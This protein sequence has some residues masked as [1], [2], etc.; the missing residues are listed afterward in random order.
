MTTLNPQQYAA[1]TSTAPAILCIAGAGTGKTATLTARIKHLIAT[2]TPPKHITAL[3]FT[4]KAAAEML[5]RVGAKG[6]FIDTF[7]AWCLRMMRDIG[8]TAGWN[9][10]RLSIIDDGDQ[11]KIMDGIKK[12]M[13]LKPTKNPNLKAE[14]AALLRNEYRAFCLTHDII[15]YDMLQ[16]E[17]R[18]ILTFRSLGETPR[19]RGH[20]LIDEFQDTDPVQYEIIR[21]A[22]EHDNL[23]VVGDD[24]QSIYGFRGAD[25]G[26]I[27]QF[28]SDF[29]PEIVALTQNYRSG[30]GILDY[31]NAIEVAAIPKRLWSEIPAGTVEIQPCDAVADEALYVAKTAPALEGTTA[32]IG[33]TNSYLDEF[34]VYLE[35]EKVEFTRSRRTVWTK[36]EKASINLLKTIVTGNLAW[37]QGYDAVHVASAVP[38]APWNPTGRLKEC[39]DQY[40]AISAMLGEAWTPQGLLDFIDTYENDEAATV[41]PG[42]NLLT[43]HGSKGLEF[44]NVFLVGCGEGIFPLAS[45][46]AGPPRDEASRLLY[47]A[48]TRA[49]SK[50][51]ISW[52]GEYWSWGKRLEVTRSS[53]LPAARERNVSE[54]R[55]CQ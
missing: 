36:E 47:V 17:I 28:I 18:N 53:L 35:A 22:G 7:H 38:Q 37:V 19:P 48:V 8:Y 21:L 15:D 51:F 26:N 41:Q 2:G 43:I 54:R 49:K 16:I 33:R 20:T 40:D 13:G 45:E 50:L 25:V 44:D 32:I 1:T 9:G 42:I 30:Q 31:A 39:C 23:F 10:E 46:M 3:T 29:S 55:G 4:K 34:A 27:Q 52:P 14:Q 24:C 11:K 12:N 6:V 5:H